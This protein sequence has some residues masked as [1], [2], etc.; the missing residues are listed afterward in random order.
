LK[1]VLYGLKQAPR[2]WYG[3]IDSFLTSLG[4][5][6]SKADSN[7]YFK[8]MNDEPVILLLYVDDLFLTGEEKLITDCKKKLAVE[9]KMKDLDL[10]HY[11][12]G[13]E[14]WQSP[15][16]I[17]LNQGKYAVEILK[18]FDMLE[19]K[20]MNTPMETNLT[21]LVDTSSELVDA[22]MYRHIIGSLMYLT[23]TRP[24]ICSVVNTLSQYQVEPRRV[25]LVAAKHVMRYLKGTLTS[26]C[27]VILI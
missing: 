11:F 6:K 2:A 12:L 7:L 14:V 4:F 16:K 8:V 24:D 13:L 5:T 19:C 3:R 10:M 23:N 9:F 17:F 18:R 1:K 27:M 15:E 25:H 21:L 20:S 22:T 26:N